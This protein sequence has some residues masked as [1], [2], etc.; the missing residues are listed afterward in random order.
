MAVSVLSVPVNVVTL[1]FTNDNL[2]MGAFAA[3]NP[4]LHC[5]VLCCVVLC[6][7]V[8]VSLPCSVNQESGLVNPWAAQYTTWLLINIDAKRRSLFFSFFSCWVGRARG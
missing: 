4:T 1:L 7:A 6:C 2:G 8:L 3:A 5:A